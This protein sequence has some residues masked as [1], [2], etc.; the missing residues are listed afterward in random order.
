MNVAAEAL[1][2]LASFSL[3]RRNL[4]V[5]TCI[6]TFSESTAY[7]NN[8]AQTKPWSVPYHLVPYHPLV[9]NY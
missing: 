5:L 1:S 7:E 3:H 9:N 8:G 6:A 4:N 2:P